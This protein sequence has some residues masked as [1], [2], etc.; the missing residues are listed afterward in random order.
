MLNTDKNFGRACC[1]RLGAKS[2]ESH[3]LLVL[4]LWHIV[5]SEVQQFKESHILTTVLQQLN[6]LQTVFFLLLITKNVS[7]NTISTSYE[8]FIIFV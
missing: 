6:I 7:L 8:M 5:S 1:I 4:G 3:E 2:D